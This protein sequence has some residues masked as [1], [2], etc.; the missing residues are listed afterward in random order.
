M[1]FEETGELLEL[2]HDKYNRKE[3]I[4]KDPVSIPHQFSQKEDIEI[5]GF[6]AAIFSWGQR[7]TIINKSKDLLQRMDNSPSDFIR[8]HK[9]N[10]LKRFASFSHRTFN[11]IDCDY[12]IKALQIIYTKQG[13][14]EKVIC[15]EF[16]NE[17]RLESNLNYFRHVF[18]QSKHL[19]RTEKHLSS[20]ES[21][22][23]CKRM[24]M[25]LRWMVRKDSRGVDFGIWKSLSPADLYC[26][27]D[28]HSARMA[29]QLGLLTRKQ[30]D[31]KAVVE[32]TNELQKFDKKD[33]VRFDFSL[34]GSGVEMK[35]KKNIV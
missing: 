20:P 15:S 34:F 16:S 10:D 31:W 24:N 27:L 25:F 13:G 8:N 4:D 14:L 18:F 30:N 9:A 3:F 5:A 2:Y 19:S 35:T 1:T 28:V 6:F 11:G 21:Q 17:D 12:F 22:S 29:R 7:Q 32:L 26:P 23:A 33:P